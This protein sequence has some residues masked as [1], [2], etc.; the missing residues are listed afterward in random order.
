MPTT[1]RIGLESIFFPLGFFKSHI[2]SE[3]RR[4][5][6]CG[7]VHG[8]GW[9]WWSFYPF[10]SR[11]LEESWE[12]SCRDLM[13][14]YTRKLLQYCY[15]IEN[16]VWNWGDATFSKYHQLV[17]L[18]VLVTK[19]SMIAC[20]EKKKSDKILKWMLQTFLTMSPYWTLI[21]SAK[22]LHRASAERTWCPDARVRGLMDWWV[23]RLVVISRILL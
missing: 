3:R 21:S 20:C 2:H 13:T 22:I 10:S 16:V 1:H 17:S 19:L 7:L 14:I 8:W 6:L 5:E 4:C 11:Y 18:Q 12:I 9:G 15:R 23:L